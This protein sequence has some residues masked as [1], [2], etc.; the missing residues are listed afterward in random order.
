MKGTA[1]AGELLRARYLMSRESH[2]MQGMI[3]RQRTRQRNKA[4]RVTL[5][6]RLIEVED[7]VGT[8]LLPAMALNRLLVR[9]GIVTRAELSAIADQLAK[10]EDETSNS[11][12]H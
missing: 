9:Q 10:N 1:M 7:A 2:R 8:V 4:N 11:Y 12:E 3:D 5:D 6:E